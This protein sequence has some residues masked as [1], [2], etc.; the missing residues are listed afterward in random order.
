MKTPLAVGV[1]V[2]VVAVAIAL[3]TG[4]LHPSRRS[5]ES[6]RTVSGGR[7][8]THLPN[9]P[10]K[11]AAA[12]PRDVEIAR[13]EEAAPEADI[14][15]SPFLQ[16]VRAKLTAIARETD[17]ARRE[18]MVDEIVS[19]MESGDAGEAIAL[20]SRQKPSEL[21]S[22]IQ[23]HFLQQWAERDPQAAANAAIEMPGQN[24]R[25]A[26]E[27]VL[28][29]W[30]DGHLGD[31]IAWVGQMPDGEE[32]NRARLNVA[33]EA[34]RTEPETAVEIAS[35]LPSSPERD[36]MILHAA[37]QWAAADPANASV[38]AQ[39]LEDGPL[40]E[41]LLALIATTWG[42]SDPAAAAKL[43]IEGLSAGKTQNDALVSIVQRWTQK[44]A[45][46]V[47]AWVSNFP[48]GALRS[49]AMEN[50]IKLWAQND[51]RP[52]GE[53]LN[54]LPAGSSRDHAL[55]AYS[56]QI[57]PASPREAAVWAA[58]ITDARMRSTQLETIARMWLHSDRSAAMAWISTT[59]FSQEARNRILQ[60]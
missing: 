4:A 11:E 12:P 9:E 27:A 53:W 36:E 38:W 2:I 31:A 15:L 42:E 45:A 49:A 46:A 58:A 40:R 24:R 44:D 13:T 26:L 17:P 37:T 21:I 52:A 23:G 43:A 22:E 47:G 54:G 18:Q 19:W 6:V 5:E 32:K 59:P 7:A 39:A 33:L 1:C 29:V 57:A 10:A 28:G 16:E 3:E 55:R 8:G 25:E 20:L 48:E 41:R 56:E 50:F 60:K 51:A 30:A 34:A 14:Q 35:D